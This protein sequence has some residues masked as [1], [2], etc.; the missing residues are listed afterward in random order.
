M[1]TFERVRSQSTRRKASC[2]E[3]LSDRL[4]LSNAES[5]ALTRST[6]APYPCVTKP[7]ASSVVCG[8]KLR[9]SSASS[10]PLHAAR[11]LLALWLLKSS[12]SALVRPEESARV[13]S[14]I[15]AAELLGETVCGLETSVEGR[16]CE[17]GR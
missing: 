8:L 12:E 6:S 16:T 3:H 5:A 4:H 10:A 13:Y 17:R 14:R 7:T 9:S 15:D 2:T 11:Q 1:I